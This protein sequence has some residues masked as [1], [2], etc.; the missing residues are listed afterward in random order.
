MSREGRLLLITALT[1]IAFATYN[2]FTLG[3]FLF[4]FPLNEPALFVI[5]LQLAYWYREHRTDALFLSLIGV[6][7]LASGMVFWETILSHEQ[8][9]QFY[10]RAIPDLLLLTFYISVSV[11]MVRTLFKAGAGLSRQGIILSLALLAT[12]VILNVPYLFLPAY[13]LMIFAYAA[14]KLPRDG[15]FWLWAFLT[16]FEFVKGSMYVFS[17]ALF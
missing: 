7:A 6:F 3:T 12:A 15:I 11:L 17:G 10:E 1:Y 5:C 2:L 16:F 9:F 4:P 8:L 13:V 14:G